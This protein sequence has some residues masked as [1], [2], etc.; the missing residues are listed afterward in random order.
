MCLRVFVAKHRLFG[1]NSKIQHLKSIENKI[2]Q[3]YKRWGRDVAS[4]II[5]L[6]SSGSSRKYYRLTGH[7]GTILAVYNDNLA[8]NKAFVGFTKHFLNQ[9]LPVPEVYD[10]FPAENIYFLQDLGDVTLFNYIETNRQRPDF[11]IGLLKLYRKVI[12]KLTE[13]QFNG[14]IGLDYELCYPRKAFD[15]QSVLWDLNYF[16][17]YF[18]K[19]A[20]IPFNE[21]LLE[22]D[23]NTLAAFLL[24][25]SGEYFLYRDFQS[26]NIMIFRDRLYFIDY[27]GG[28]MGALQYD[29]ASLLY[30]AKADLSEALR[31]ELLNYY[32]DKSAK[33]KIDQVKFLKYYFSYVLVRIMQAMGSYGYRGYFERKHHFLASIPFAIRNLKFIMKN[34]FPEINI[35][36]L[37]TVLQSVTESD[38]LLKLHDIPSDK[39][40]VSIFSFAYKNGIPEDNSGHGGGFVYDCRYL[41]NP[42]REEKF[43]KMTGYNKE[44]IEYLEAFPETHDFLHHISQMIDQSIQNYLK[45]NFSNLMISFGCTGG[46]HRSVYF[47]N[48]LGE[49]IKGKFDVKVEVKHRELGI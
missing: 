43:R 32:M 12:D 40:K 14:G 28:R 7:K 35:P 30:D 25:A 17:Y 5:P 10:F 13:F 45:R 39:L 18:L 2:L 21:Q 34:H 31:D 4:D 19:L 38:N 44:V 37:T 41:P 23:F 49:Y 29:L 48:K 24:E 47:A 46:Q 15:R 3:V 9:N 6:Q 11:N 22:N 8:E 1:V 27:Q 42:G 20:G 33:Y 26:R 16:K 36:E